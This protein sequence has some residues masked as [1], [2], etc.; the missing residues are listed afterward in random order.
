MTAT[1]SQQ[2]T[3][4]PCPCCGAYAG[5]TLAQ[6]E[7]A[8]L[9][10]VD[11]LAIKALEV[12]GKR[13]V[14]QGRDRFA[15]RTDLALPWHQCHT[16]WGLDERDIDRVMVGAWDVVPALLSPYGLSDAVSERLVRFLDGY[17]RGLL[18]TRG[19]YDAQDLRARLTHLVGASHG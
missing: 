18:L 1:A 17:I 8:I 2:Q 3:V 5:A 11:V 10:A 6:R 14:R 12:A 15:A 4:T 9:A 19:R 7:S 16:K 13:I